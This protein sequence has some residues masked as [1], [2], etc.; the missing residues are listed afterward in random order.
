MT[1][2]VWRHPKPLA[3]DG[4]CLGQNDM[5][6]DPRKIKRLANQIQRFVRVHQL[7]KVIWVSPLQ[8]SL[9]VGQVLAQRGFECHVAKDLV[10]INFG[11]WNGRP[12]EHIAK[13]EIDNW[14]SDFANFAPT[15][16]ESL[17]QLFVR[18]Q[19]W[20]H[21]QSNNKTIGSN[22]ILVVGH[23]GWITAATMIT[24]AKDIPI[25]AADW[26]RPVAYNARSELVFV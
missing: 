22:S 17:Q 14:C 8:R 21:L 1:I 12:W 18:V 26:P 4:L 23:A 6:V 5:G 7:P 25:I 24:A 13:Q 16:G 2:Y 19:D 10:E 20:L 15:D 11:V 9:A 3:A